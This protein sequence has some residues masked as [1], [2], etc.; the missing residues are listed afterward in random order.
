VQLSDR[1]RPVVA[2]DV[3]GVLR[4]RRGKAAELDPPGAFVAEVT[5]FRYAY[6]SVFHSPPTWDDD[7][8]STGRHM[9][10]GVGAA[11]V[12]SLL[13]R[14]VEVVWATTWQHYANEY[15][16]PMLGIPP[17]PVAV[18]GDDEREWGPAEWKSV[19][20]ADGFAG[21]PLL[22]V[23]DMPPIR[24]GYQLDELR[25]PRDRALTRLQWI[26]DPTVGLSSTDV[27]EMNEWLELA[28]TEPGH[29][30]LRRRRRRERAQLRDE[31]DTANHGSRARGRRWRRMRA[32]LLDATPARNLGAAGHIATYLLDHPD[33]DLA[34]VRELAGFWLGDESDIQAIVG[35]AAHLAA[36]G[37]ASAS[38]T[39]QREG[40]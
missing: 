2:V 25:K 17:L 28:T 6:P 31:T 40:R 36:H 12:R 29:A 24:A 7:G 34:E 32:F 35:A 30:E 37:G 27:T 26:R 18:R 14:D 16:A 33:P 23:D 38:P 3:D 22:W 11:W 13:D 1:Y 5:V 19:Q 20:L 10:S 4:L 39:I 15:F 8:M 9:F 21:R